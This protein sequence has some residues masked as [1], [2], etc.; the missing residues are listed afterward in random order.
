MAYGI[1][2]WWR[3]A[4]AFEY[5]QE[6]YKRSKLAQ[7]HQFISYVKSNTENSNDAVRELALEK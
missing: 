1:G 5:K 7:S 6:N 4:T 2:G 3:L